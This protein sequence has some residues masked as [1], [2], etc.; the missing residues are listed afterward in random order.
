MAAMVRR[1]SSLLLSLS[2]VSALSLPLLATSACDKSAPQHPEEDDTDRL[3]RAL[4][5]G[6]AR[7]EREAVL[8][9]ASDTLA[10]DL[11]ERDVT[12]IAR[13]LDWLGGLESAERASEEAVAGGV[14]RRYELAFGRGGVGLTLTVVGGKIEG[15]EFDAQQWAALEDRAAEAAA[16]ELRVAEF[17]W[18]DAEGKPVS[19]PPDPAAINYELGIEG[20]EAQLREHHVVIAKSVLDGEGNQVYRQNDDDDIRFPQ[21]E[22]G[23]S[24]GRIT[25]SVAVPGPGHY[26][27]ELQIRDLVGDQSMTHR[28]PLVIE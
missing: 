15:F 22:S 16:G 21:A 25:G 2:L 11:D 23:S 20:L 7:G 10:A 12:I 28:V 8:A 6:L 18:L 1:S 4:L 27:L 3:V 14:R 17:H 13:T 26:E 19:A 5:D 24:G 9:L